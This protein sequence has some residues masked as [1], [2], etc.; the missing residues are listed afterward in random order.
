MTPDLR[1]DA[2]NAIVEF[3]FIALVMLVPLVYLLVAVAVVQRSQTAV[4]NAARDAGR[5]FVTSGAGDDPAARVAAAVRLALAARHLPD[6]AT[7]RAVAFDETCQG[8]AVEPRLEPGA[9]FAICVTRRQSIPGVPSV[10]AGREITSV[11]R[12]V[13]HVDD[14]RAPV[15]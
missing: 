5:A 3:V 10:L 6:D 13:V 12:Y 8:P 15:R 9:R 14:F 4:T 2:G 11:G 1:D 7:V